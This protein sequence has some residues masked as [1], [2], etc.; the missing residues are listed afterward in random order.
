MICDHYRQVQCAAS[1][2][3]NGIRCVFNRLSRNR[4]FS[5]LLALVAVTLVGLTPTAVLA[6]PINYGNFPVPG[7]GISFLQVTES[8]GTDAVP[9][10]GPPTP[11]FVGLD[12]DPTSFA[13]SSASGSADITDGQ[14]NFTVMGNGVGIDSLSLHESGDYSLLGSGTTATQAIAGA[15][16]ASIKVTQIDGL[17]A[18]V[19]LPPVSVSTSFNLVANPGIVQPWS[20]GLSS[21]INAQLA[22]MNIPFKVGATKVVVALNNS[23]ATLSEA[24]SI[25]F[26]AKKDFTIGIIPH[27]PEPS[28]LVLA[29]V[30]SI[31]LGCLK[32]TRRAT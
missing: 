26:I 21:P 32:I 22:S 2:A 13:S 3:P 15:V 9:L 20:I 27:V 10:Y 19:T 14:L 7:S 23:L 31:A 12:F 6:S 5:V 17:P 30:A 28:T 24:G 18:N 8:S 25:A 4:R 16:L 1:S 11:F 29:A